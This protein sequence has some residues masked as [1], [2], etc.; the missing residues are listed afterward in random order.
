MDV[1]GFS[2]TFCLQFALHSIKIEFQQK[3]LLYRVSLSLSLSL[4]V[5]FCYIVY[6]AVS[7]NFI[8]ISSSRKWIG[9]SFYWKYYRLNGVVARRWKFKKTLLVR[10]T[11][12][13]VTVAIVLF[14]R[15]FVVRYSL[16]LHLFVS[17]TIWRYLSWNKHCK[18]VDETHVE[19]IKKWY[20]VYAI[21]LRFLKIFLHT[22]YK[23]R[24]TI[25]LLPK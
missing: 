25:S 20:S 11:K 4:W 17:P 6:C 5:K 9:S 14:Y 15:L 24:N 21:T 18:H 16:F 13:M 23:T 3:L 12:T 1:R 22:K 2:S 7:I 8:F 10:L 19:L